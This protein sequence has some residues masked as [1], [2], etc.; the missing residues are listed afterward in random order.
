MTKLSSND[1]VRMNIKYYRTLNNITQRQIS[2]L[3]NV[4]EKHY[5]NLE[6]GHYNYTLKNLDI[7]AELL[8]KEV[9]ELLK[10]RHT[11]KEIDNLK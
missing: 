4:D 5:C 2:E 1:I 8:N 3:L 10:E 6:N 11:Q 9:W 7:I